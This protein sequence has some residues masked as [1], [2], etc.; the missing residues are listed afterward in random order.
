MGRKMR[1]REFLG[2]CEEGSYMPSEVICKIVEG[3][4]DMQVDFSQEEEDGL[5]G[6][7]N[8]NGAPENKIFCFPM[9][10]FYIYL[11]SFTLV[12]V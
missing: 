1:T 5:L 6:K 2:V 7:W 9:Q 8:L 4:E 3:S 11:M 10:L 12:G